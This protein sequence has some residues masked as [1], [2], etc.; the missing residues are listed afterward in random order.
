MTESVADRAQ[1]LFKELGR[2]KRFAELDTAL[3]IWVEICGG[4]DRRIPQFANIPAM[5]SG[6]Y[7][8][9]N[10]RQDLLRELYVQRL[11]RYEIQ[12]NN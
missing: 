6:D 9:F 7:S 3:D 8:L 1:K 11:G 4:V 12:S 10:A 2:Q 5:V